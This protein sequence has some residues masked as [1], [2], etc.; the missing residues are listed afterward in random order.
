MTGKCRPEKYLW[1]IGALPWV[2]FE[3][4]ST[5]ISGC[6]IYRERAAGIFASFDVHRGLGTVAKGVI[7]CEGVTGVFQSVL[8][9]RQNQSKASR[10]ENLGFTLDRGFEFALFDNK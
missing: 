3:K 10:P 6:H 4:P 1:L 9:S 8:F 2:F 5:H 7:G